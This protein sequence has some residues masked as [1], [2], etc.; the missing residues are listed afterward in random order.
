MG[1]NEVGGIARRALTQV[2]DAE[3]PEAVG[4]VRLELID[5]EGRPLVRGNGGAQKVPCAVLTFP[6]KK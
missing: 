6:E 3:H 2:V 1:E 4:S 5:G